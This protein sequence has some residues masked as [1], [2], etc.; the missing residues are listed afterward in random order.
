[1]PDEFAKLRAK[2]QQTLEIERMKRQM[3]KPSRAT[4][5]LG[6]Y[7]LSHM[8]AQNYTI[9]TMA[10]AVGVKPEVMDFLLM[11]DIPNWMINDELLRRLGRTLDIPSNQ[12]KIMLKRSIKPAVDRV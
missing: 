5:L 6:A 12:L 10:K 11:G 7:L 4:Q 8:E 9:E 2:V 1:M 3:P